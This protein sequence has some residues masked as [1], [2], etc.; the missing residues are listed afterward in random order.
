MKNW[1]THLTQI[2]QNTLQ[3]I[4]KRSTQRSVRLAVTGLSQAGKST[5]I[6]ALLHQ[7]SHAHNSNNLPFFKII[8][9]GYFL[10]AKINFDTSQS[11]PYFP[12]HDALQLLREQ[13][14]PP[15]T[16]KIS[17]IE[18]EIHYRP[19]GFYGHLS[20]HAVLHLEIIDYPGE[21]LLDLPLL[22][23]NY[24]DWCRVIT[25]LCR[26]KPRLSLSEKWRSYLQQQPLNETADE[27]V[28]QQLHLLYSDFLLQCKQPEYSL[29]LIQPGRFVLPGDLKDDPLLHFCPCIDP[30]K[31][32][33]HFSPHS[34]YKVLEKRYEAYKDKVIKQFYQQHFSHF[35]RQV[36]LVD[37]LKTLNHGMES[38]QDMQEA[39]QTIMRNFQYGKSSWLRR[40][41]QPKIDKL[42]FAATKAD[43]ASADQRRNLR[44]FLRNIISESE[45][46]IRC[47]QV[48]TDILQLAA[49]ACSKSV[50][51]E[52][53]GKQQSCIVG[54]DKQS[55]KEIRV[56]PGEI[57]DYVPDAAN[58][59]P[60]KR[61][62]FIDFLPPNVADIQAN[63]LPHINMDKALEYLLGDKLL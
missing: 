29:S 22:Q 38:Y 41:F 46:Q 39:L 2:S 47:E 35:D 25:R 14:W 51:A 42:L 48:E 43:H 58:W 4:T 34:L 27:K 56:F 7:L 18:V 50:V 44:L 45:N 54:M 53:N 57:P 10:G 49:I 17:S 8:N 11:L 21:W 9:A 12:Y 32:T 6:T 31:D 5:F 37:V 33:K 26:T 19:Q 16:D 28:L 23:Q 15:G 63:H 60:Q 62:R 13:Q 55:G 52:V 24:A 36:V 3:D 20:E 61:F 1:F 30:P 40:L 59:H